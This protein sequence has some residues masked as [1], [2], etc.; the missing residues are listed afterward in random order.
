MDAEE[1]A[2]EI[3]ASMKKQHGGRGII[4]SL[5]FTKK[6]RRESIKKAERRR[7]QASTSSFGFSAPGRSVS[8]TDANDDEAG[9]YLTVNEALNDAANEE[10]P[11]PTLIASNAEGGFGFDGAATVQM[12]DLEKVKIEDCG[13]PCVVNG[14][15]SG[16]VRFVGIHAVKDVPRVGVELDEPNGKNNGTVGGHKY[17]ECSDNHGLLT[18]EAKISFT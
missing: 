7:S 16:I 15:G 11:A 3:E 9:G 13:R 5:F 8:A 12:V 18:T 4:S 10:A 2:K 1:K 6:A 17:F 14:A